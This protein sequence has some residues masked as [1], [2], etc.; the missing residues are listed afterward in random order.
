MMS[1]A[2]SRNTY[3]VDASNGSDAND[4]LSPDSAWRSIEHVNDQSFQ[5]GDQILFK[6]GDVY[7]TPLEPAQSGTA[8]HPIEYGA[9]GQGANPVFLGSIDLTDAEWTQTSPG[10]G[11]WT[12][13]APRI[14]QIE[15]GK[16]FLDGDT[17]NTQATG[18]SAVDEPGD[19]HWS[20]DQVWVFANSDPSQAFNSIELQV[21]DAMI[22]VDGV[23]HIRVSDLDAAQS[24]K[25][26][27]LEDTTGTQVIESNAY[28][29]SRNG[30]ELNDGASGNLV[31]GGLFYDNGILAEG[32]ATINLGHGVLING[33]ASDN[34]VS[35]IESYRN[36]EDGVQFGSASGSGNRIVGST[37]YENFED[38]V[39]IK[40]GD[41]HLEANVVRDNASNAVLIHVSPTTTTLVGN[42]L[43][44]ADGANALDVSD[45]GRVVSSG[46]RY[47]GADSD[48]VDLQ[49]SAGD[50]ST[51]EGDTFIDGGRLSQIS[52]DV[53]GG[54]GHVFTDSTFIQR[55][56]GD[57]L[58]VRQ[59]ADDVTVTD[60]VFFTEQAR[61]VRYAEGT[62]DLDRNIYVRGDGDAN[63][64]WVEESPRRE[65]SREDIVSGA[66]AQAEG[67]DAGSVVGDAAWFRARLAEGDLP[68]LTDTPGA[69]DDLVLS[70][71]SGGRINGLAGDDGLFAKTGTNTLLGK[72]GDD[73]LFGGNGRDTL[74]GGAGA[75]TLI[76]GAGNDTLRFDAQ[77]DRVD[78]QDGFDRAIA[79][80]NEGVR[81]DLGANNLEYARGTSAADTLFTDGDNAV[82]LI[83]DQGDDVLTGGGGADN[84]QGRNGDDELR[85]R[86][87]ND[88]LTGGAGADVLFG[89]DGDDTLYFDADDTTVDGGA[90]QDRA[91]AQGGGPV[92]LD[93]GAA[94]V[95]HV[96]GTGGD[97]VFTGG[98]SAADLRIQ[99]LGGDDAITGGTGDD[100]L[101]GNG[102]DDTLAGGAGDDTI[103]GGTGSDVFVF[104]SGGG[105]D[106]ITDFEAGAGGD[107]LDLDALLSSSGYTGSDP[108]E[109]GY[110]NYRQ[111]GGKV[112]VDFDANGGG[113][114]YDPVATLNN[115]LVDDMTADNVVV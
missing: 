42:D 53:S 89:G 12:T 16:I 39:D 36:A 34:T 104:D 82:Q 23:D 30:I 62:V 56:F 64:I 76:G 95:E 67:V 31:E 112:M 24:R 59:D 22:R 2:S 10:S 93:L 9:Y 7:R 96:K 78:G 13:D 111:S 3:Y 68:T 63:W 94:N 19:W 80:G 90:G 83:G 50:G 49:R 45:G 113:D 84:L 41:Q 15:P 74:D 48:A 29:N 108:F 52:V 71:G 87:G 1:D 37:L 77:D 11:V 47:S 81:L 25:G 28:D 70:D 100:R 66:Y 85:G 43:S 99:G 60:S 55:N 97:D 75:D 4:G 20:D 115:V 86:A 58:W 92:S 44:T 5:P 73:L 18:P 33:G 114:S 72:E 69:G 26:I 88:E 32:E 103:T 79:T 65:Y 107:R 40:A 14:N 105:H 51:F 110:V 101:F 109:D 17:G 21:Q 38:G 8:D 91:I 106:T 46:N 35:G 57:A 102:G 61:V 6:R 54:S 98:T 27:V